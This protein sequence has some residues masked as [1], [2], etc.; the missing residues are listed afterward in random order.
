MSENTYMVQC[1]YW[2][3]YKNFY[4]YLMLWSGILPQTGKDLVIYKVD[5]KLDQ[6]PV[7]R[8]W[9]EYHFFF[10]QTMGQ[11]MYKWIAAESEL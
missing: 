2:P 9:R 6:A 7:W 3:Y 1:D 11:I 5:V 4:S 8:W 10:D